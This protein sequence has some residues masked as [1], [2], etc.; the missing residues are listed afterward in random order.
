VPVRELTDRDSMRGAL[1]V[2]L[3]ILEKTPERRILK[4][5]DWRAENSI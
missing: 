4:F 3:E 2:L 5:D 1:E